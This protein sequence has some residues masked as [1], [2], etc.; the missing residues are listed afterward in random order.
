MASSTACVAIA[1][2]KS[3]SRAT[4][5]ALKW[6][7]DNNHH[8]V[9]FILIHVMQPITSG[10]F[11]SVMEMDADIVS[12][13]RQ[14][15]ILKCDEMFLPYKRFCKSRKVETLVLE[16]ENPAYAL[17]SYVSEKGCKSLVLG[18][19]S[20]NY[21]ARKL[22]GPDVPSTILKLAPN[23][24]NIYVVARH[25]LL[26]NLANS[27]S[28]AGIGAGHEMLTQTEKRVGV[29]SVDRNELH[30]DSVE[31]KSYK[32]FEESPEDVSELSLQASTYGGSSISTVNVDPKNELQD[33]LERMK[34]E[35][36][37]TL[38]MYD[39]A[40]RDLVHV[41]NK[42]QSLSS[43]CLEDAR[44]L[45][46]VLDREEVLRNI[47]AEEKSN[48]L[49]AMKE[50]EVSKQL[51]ARESHERQKAELNA[52]T[53]SSM[54]QEILNALFSSDKRY[55]KYSKDEIELA[56]EFFSDTKK[57]GEG[58]YGKVYKCTL[59]HTPVAIKVLHPDS[60][61]KKQEFLREVEV[62]SQL[63][64]PHLVLLLAACPEIG[65]LVYE[66]M[67]NGS[68]EELLF[69][70]KSTPPLPWFVRFRMAFE[71]ASGL[72]FLHSSKPEPIVHTDLK[73]GNILLDRNFVTKIGD[74]GL[75]KFMSDVVPDSVTEYRDSV[76][77]GT[78]YYMD[79]EY[80]RT[81]TIRPKS[82]VY[83]FGVIL[84]QLLTARHPKGLIS[85]V[86]NAISSGS[87]ADILD[88][89]ISDWPLAE[90]EELAGIAL[91][92]SK[93]RCRDRPDLE[94]EVLPM[95]KRLKS[96]ADSGFHLQKDSIY[97]PNNYFCPILQEVMND[98]YVA[99]DGFTYEYR[100]IKAWLEKHSVSPVT[101]LK[102][103]HTM[104]TPN[105]ALHSFIQEWRQ[106]V[107]C[108]SS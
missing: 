97:A 96:R 107:T 53:E 66:Y 93:L 78:V 54:K 94:F 28:V 34:L 90:S 50:V 80:H 68:L 108:V 58:G 27:S 103:P 105:N 100:A 6:A 11:V 45:N 3:G 19:S 55:R 47:V 2:S 25:K 62:L 29:D 41:Q 91:K 63:R 4:Q 32:S 73:P 85:A 31:S 8:S 26:K 81:G 18:Y 21:I 64:H 101:R 42:V 20:L 102:L 15:M 59:D 46:A 86:E 104:L 49:E 35:L 76:L 10:N 9:N 74:V 23:T 52:L 17:S 36:Q 95:L 106:R 75:A 44:R 84:L 77:A 14:D 48:H 83:A 5:R 1:V 43:E 89:S 37:A 13:Y 39:R 33:E 40:C 16:D 30:C 7:M 87:F 57:I 82:D 60:S 56:T 67:E 38:E 22:K 71:V 65:C 92:C 99:A 98:P 72:A 70:R 24:C 51:L 12:M 69:C 88:K 61:D 79:P